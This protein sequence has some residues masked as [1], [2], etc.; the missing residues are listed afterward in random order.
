[1]QDICEA[2]HANVYALSGMSQQTRETLP[3]GL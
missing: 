1:M 2:I 3:K